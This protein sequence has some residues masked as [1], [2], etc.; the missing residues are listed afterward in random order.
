[1]ITDDSEEY[2]NGRITVTFK[3][4]VEPETIEEILGDF[5]YKQTFPTADPDCNSAEAELS[6]VYTVRMPAEKEREVIRE[7][8]GNQ[9]IKAV[10]RVPRRYALRP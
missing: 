6:R 1:M 9:Y 3:E 5:E 4:D 10:D 2:V 7:L 8:R